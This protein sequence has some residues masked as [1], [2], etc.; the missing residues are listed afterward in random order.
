[1]NMAHST[2]CTSCKTE[3]TACHASEE[4]CCK[5]CQ[6]QDTHSLYRVGLPS[7]PTITVKQA[8]EA[9]AS[10]LYAQNRDATN[11]I[12]GAEVP[13]WGLADEITRRTFR[14]RVT[15]YIEGAARS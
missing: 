7:E 15:P 8:I 1:M 9:A 4:A 6:Y 10:A 11:A 3:R 5:D 2:N 13:P 12:A 14:L